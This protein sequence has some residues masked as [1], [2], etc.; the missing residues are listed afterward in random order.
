LKKEPK[1][2]Y[3]QWHK[4]FPKHRLSAK[5]KFAR[6]DILTKSKH[7]VHF[8]IRALQAQIRIGC[9]FPATPKMSKNR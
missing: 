1:A 8:V 4:Q 2:F 3:G 9:G 7:N 5:W 6:F